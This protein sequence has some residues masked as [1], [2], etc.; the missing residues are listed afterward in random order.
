MQEEQK[1][2]LLFWALIR[3]IARLLTHGHM[4]AFHTEGNQ[5]G[6]GGLI[7]TICFRHSLKKEG[8]SDMRPRALPG[9][10][11]NG[12]GGRRRPSAADQEG[13]RVLRCEG[14]QGVFRC[15]FSK[16]LGA[17]PWAHPSPYPGGAS[18]LVRC[19]ERGPEN[20]QMNEQMCT[21]PLGLQAAGK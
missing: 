8:Q 6:S 16:Y 13:I 12:K 7:L 14:G 19:G 5:V 20:Q 4:E 3:A 17:Q 10:C 18:V 9:T 1:Y 2:S 11:T 15:S 21:M